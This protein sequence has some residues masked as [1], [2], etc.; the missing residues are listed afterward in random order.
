M[1]KRIETELPG[2]IILEPRIHEDDRGFFMETY[3]ESVF[4]ELGITDRFIQENHSRSVRDSLRGIHFQL[5]I[6]QAKLCRVI[7]GE[8]FDVVADIRTESPTFGRWTGVHLSEDNRRILYVPPGFAHGFLVLSD[9]A[10]FLY[11][12]GSYYD[13]GDE[14][15]IRWNDPSL[16]VNWPLTGAPI[17]SPRDA[18]LPLLGD[19]SADTLPEYIT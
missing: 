12:C 14:S 9:S 5:R 19:M 3:R 2:V 1:M 15:G 11:K 7:R 4:G 16:A 18:E 17:L 6:P 8:V 13:L 10:D